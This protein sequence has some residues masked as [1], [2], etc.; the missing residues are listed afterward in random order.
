MPANVTSPEVR[1]LQRR[2]PEHVGNLFSPGAWQKPH[3][4]YALDNGRFTASNGDWSESAYRKLLDKALGHPWPP[5]WALCP[6]VVGDWDATRRE[7]DIWHPVLQGMGFTVALAVQDG[8]TVDDVI[9]MAP[10]VVFV[11]GTVE[12]KWHKVGEWAENFPHVHVGR[13]NS[14]E[15]SFQ[16]FKMGVRSIDGTGW[17]RTTRQRRLL[18]KLLGMMTGSVATQTLLI[19][20]GSFPGTSER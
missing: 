12:W 3:G 6:D 5:M 9:C 17:M 16:C 7:W 13:V 2:Y 11:G 15:Q 10:H 4:R 18:R 19:P 8:A 1:E 20:Y 14:L